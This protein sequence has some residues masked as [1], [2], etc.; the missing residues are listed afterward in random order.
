VI[1]D[2]ITPTLDRSIEE[3]VINQ[4]IIDLVDTFRIYPMLVHE[5]FSSVPE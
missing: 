4:V 1:I 5:F 2:E 3:L